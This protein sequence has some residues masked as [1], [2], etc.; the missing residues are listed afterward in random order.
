M[1]ILMTPMAIVEMAKMAVLAIIANFVKANGNF[2]MAKRDI[3]LKSV[4]KLAQ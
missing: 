3:Q 4:R 2:S 1:V